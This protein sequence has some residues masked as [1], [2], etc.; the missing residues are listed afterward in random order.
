M[1]YSTTMEEKT[2]RKFGLIGKDIDYSFSRGYFAEKF[3]QEKL[4]HCQYLNYDCATI[5]E[6][7]TTLK[8]TDCVGLNVTIPY[9]EK[10]IPALDGLAPQA[11]EIGAVN[12]VVFHAD[13]RREGHNTDAYG[14]ERALFDQWT[15]KNPK[16]L[17]LGTGGASKAIA[18]VLKKKGIHIQYVSRSSL[19]NTLT[20]NQ[21]TPALIATHELIVNCTPLGTYPNT[22]EAP[23]IPYNA[24][25]DQ[26]L[27]FDLIYNPPMTEFM[28]RG[29][30]KG[31]K[32][33]NGMQMLI[34]QAERSWSLWNS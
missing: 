18:Y 4:N 16:A 17:I 20:Y 13:G 33:I 3:S 6:V 30:A 29:Q 2:V 31:A 5:E 34:H 8:Q 11:K 24:L 27:L 12:T 22:S 14:F 21:L 7:F 15:P 19:N 23:P 26:H 28:K 32:T 9:K 25:S 1:H 10:I